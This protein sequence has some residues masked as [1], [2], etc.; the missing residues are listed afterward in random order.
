MKSSERHKIKENEFAHTVARTRDMVNERPRE[1]ATI[2][3]AVLAVAL[4][5]GGFF[6]WKASR[7]GKATSLL[8]SALAVAEAPVVTPPPPAPGS[9]PPVQPPGSFRTEREK[10]E[11]SVPLLQRAADAYPNNDAGITA[12][13]RLAATLAELA[14]YAE[15]EQR[16]QEVVQKAGARSIYRYTARLG[17]GEAQLAQGKGDAAV[18]TFRELSTDATSTLPVDGVLMQ[19]GRAALQAGKKDDATRAFTRVVD[20]FPQSLYAV[21]AKEK[22]AGLKKV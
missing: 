12:R 11:A 2:T 3:I 4:A 14:R 20:E 9:A 18:T 6:A 21:E 19:L 1:V 8:A 16:Y 17:V 15:A 10:L 7:D 22:I 13:Y 5:L